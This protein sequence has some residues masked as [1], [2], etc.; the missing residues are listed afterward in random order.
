MPSGDTTVNALLDSLDTIVASARI[1]QEFE[2]VM[3]QLVDKIT[4][5][6]GTGLDWKEVSFDRLTAQDITETT[7]LDNPQL[8]S[9]SAITITPTV[10]AI[11][12]VILDRVR[13]R[14][15]K[16][17]LGQIGPLAQNAMERK[18]DVDGLT[19]LDSFTNTNP[20]A[21]SILTTGTINAAVSVVRTGDD[22][23]P[24]K[25]PYRAVLH[26]YQLK[27]LEDELRSGIGTYVIDEG[28]TARV[29]KEGFRGVISGCQLYEDN[30][31][32]IDASADSKGGVFAQRAI[33]LVQ[34]RGPRV[35]HLRNE[36]LGGGADELLMYDEYAYGIR[37]NA[38]GYEIYSDTTEPTS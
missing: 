1:V 30:N 29:F 15:N 7:K 3:Q 35:V 16:T 12:T 8:L 26:S 37:L 32:D 24:S 11:H 33:V 6:E 4:L 28:L 25:P 14:L 17:A 36:K 38:W 34:G 18:K 10:A 27:D 23:E 20:G 21:G 9:D 19:V 22:T 5:K 31:I 13:A 2:G